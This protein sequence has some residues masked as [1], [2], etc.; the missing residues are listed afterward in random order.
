MLISR[1]ADAPMEFD[2]KLAKEQSDENPVYYVQYAHARIASILRHAAEQG[3]TSAGAD[4]RLLQHPAELD[5]VR[6]MLRLEEVVELAA[7]RLEPHHLP[8]YAIDLAAAFH[9]FYRE[10]RVV[11]SDPSDAEIS[12]ARLKLVET[13]KKVLA[14]ALDLMGVSAPEAM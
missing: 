14:R 2:L 4:L 11:S 3:V 10:C 9:V 6:M 12:R 8:H 5:L 13:T 7:S 1:S